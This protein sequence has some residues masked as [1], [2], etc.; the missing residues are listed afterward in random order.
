MRVLL[1]GTAVGLCFSVSV[2]R[3]QTTDL[4]GAQIALACAPP[5]TISVTPA[6]QL[7]IVGSQDNVIRSLFGVG[8]LVVLNGGTDAGLALDQRYFLRRPVLF[9]GYGVN[10]A[11]VPTI[12]QTSGWLRIV[13]ANAATAIA[14]VE[15]SCDG[16]L[17]G[18]HIEP[19]VLPEAP[20]TSGPVGEAD[21]SSLS[22]VLLGNADTRI[23]GA[24]DF[25]LIDHGRNQGVMPGTRLAIYRDLRSTSLPLVA[26]GEGVVVSVSDERGVI[27]ILSSRSAIESG[28][29]VAIRAS[30]S[31]Q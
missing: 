24:G 23:G 31:G 29:Y 6:N 14:R 7:R 3:A 25:M 13:A 2:A 5:P 9:A 27:R 16:I 26:V 4:S 10:T 30:R 28:D 8:D 21:F 12:S 17:A 15:M 18:D 19:F 20:D 11:K 22:R 1:A